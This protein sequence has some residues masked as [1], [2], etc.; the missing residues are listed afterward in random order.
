MNYFKLLL[1]IF[2]GISALV[3]FIGL[4]YLSVYGTGLLF[5]YLF[6]NLEYAFDIGG[7]SG[8]V[9]FT[10]T[11]LGIAIYVGKKDKLF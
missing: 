1:Y 2:G 6:K 8:L 10:G 5:E 11:L 9:I 7:M 3:L 4:I